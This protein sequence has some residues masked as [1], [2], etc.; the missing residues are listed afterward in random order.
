MS[1][2]NTSGVN[3]FDIDFWKSQRVI[4]T[5]L[6]LDKLFWYGEVDQQE[7]DLW[8]EENVYA[9]D[10]HIELAKTIKQNLNVNH[11][12]MPMLGEN[13]I[14][15]HFE[16][17]LWLIWGYMETGWKNPVKGINLLDDGEIH[18][19]PGTHRCVVQNFIDPNAKMPVMVNMNKQQLT[20]FDVKKELTTVEEIREELV[21]NGQVLVRTEHEEDLYVN[22]VH[23]I[24]NKNKDFTYELTGSDSWPN[25]SLDHWSDMVF[26]SLPLNVYIGH[27]SRTPSASEVCEQSI[28]ENIEDMEGQFFHDSTRHNLKR[29]LDVNVH[30]IDIKELAADGEFWR[31]S[32]GKEST[33]F[34]YTRFL[35]PYLCDYEG[36]SVFMDCDFMWRSNIFELLYFI[37]PSK[38]VSV[39][40]HDY[41]PAGAV[42]MDGKVQTTYPRKNWSSL[43]VFNNEHPST[44]RLSPHVVSTETGMY[45]HRLQWADDS[46]IGSIPVT[47]NW[48]QGDYPYNDD[49]KAV[50]FTNGGPWYEHMK[51]I[52]YSDEWR[53][54]L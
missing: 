9:T 30:L 45:L 4:L 11:I 33:E 54:Y 19:H 15:H 53:Y 47:Y 39:C 5:E 16:K 43:M 52:E 50:H 34:T 44:R 28:R 35:T 21:D 49:A 36:I 37:D 27:D 41:T 7:L 42:K 13:K 32:D 8:L 10:Y 6:P 48:L 24:G 46:E 26:R 29:E 23:E 1:Q 40:K 20:G 38:A 25:R 12:C 2:P 22:G 3:I 14:K 18:I 51:N 17:M 31:K